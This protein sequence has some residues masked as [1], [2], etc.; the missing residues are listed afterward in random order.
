[1]AAAAIMALFAA[2]ASCQ[3]V[4]QQPGSSLLRFNYSHWSMEPAGSPEEILG[5]TTVFL[6]GF[7]PIRDN[8]EARY[9]IVSAYDDLKTGDVKTSMSGLGD[10][11]LQFAHSFSRDRVLMAAGLN[12]P[13]GKTELDVDGERRII[14]YLSR[15]YLSLPLRRYGEGFGFNVQAGGA[16]ELGRFKCGLSAVYDYIGAYVPYEGYGDYDPGNAYTMTATAEVT[17][18]K[19]TYAGNVGFSYFGTDVF[20]ENDIYRQAPQFSARLMAS[21][22]GERYTTSLG[23]RIILRGRNRR[24]STTDGTIDSQLKK[25]GDEFDVFLRVAL[26][27]GG[28]WNLGTMIGT[29]QILASEEE[30][31]RS[32]LLNLAVDLNRKLSDHLDLDLGIMYHTGSTDGGAVDIGGVQMSGGLGVSY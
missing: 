23:T 31:G 14:E 18:G 10:A 28:S 7:V 32:S 29:R 2:D 17:S 22:P 12:L 4:Y 11:R 25:Y 21:R 3:I 27:V 13:T 6:S 20:E 1:M 16:T 30:F 5:Q 8:F 24:Y 26:T 15:D 19:V 9:E